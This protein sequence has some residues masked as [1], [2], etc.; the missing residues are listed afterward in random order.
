MQASSLHCTANWVPAEPGFPYTQGDHE[1]H[2]SSAPQE[3]GTCA[4]GHSVTGPVMVGT[5]ILAE[6]L[7]FAIHTIPGSV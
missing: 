4:E 1:H 5:E 2:P 7:L 6:R 3:E